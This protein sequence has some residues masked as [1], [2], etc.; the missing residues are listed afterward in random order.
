MP[1]VPVDY[2]VSV[3]DPEDGSGIDPSKIFV[4]VDYLDGYDE[5]AMSMGHQ[6]VSDAAQGETLTNG[7]D[8]R[9]CHKAAGKSIGPSYTDIALK[10]EN[11]PNTTAYLQGTIINGSTGVWGETNM[12][13]HPDLD[14]NDARLIA[15]YIQ[16]LGDKENTSMPPKGS[17]TPSEGNDGK[18]L[19]MTASYTDGGHEGIRSLTGSKRM[20]LKS[21]SFD[22]GS[23]VDVESFNPVEFGGMKLLI[24]PR[25]G[26]SF[27]YE[28]IDLTGVKSINVIAGWQSA[29][30]KGIELEI[31]ANSPDG[32]LVGTGRMDVPDED[33]ESGLIHIPVS[34]TVDGVVDKLY[35]VYN[36]KDADKFGMLT[37]AALVNV[38]FSSQAGPPSMN[39]SLM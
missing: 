30:S 13:A 17:F 5:V 3:T 12:P 32:E 7:L 26:G 31:R 25:G 38:S 1:G 28:N 15:M 14:K 37:F 35:I 27:A 18:T 11:E 34:N 23:V 10:Y 20:A 4:S 16:S 29:P 2:E 39:F 19:V 36:P 22:L 21:S 24:L 8:C 33:S 9:A 6:V